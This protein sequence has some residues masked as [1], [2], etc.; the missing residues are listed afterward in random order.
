MRILTINPGSTSTKVAVFENT[1]RIAKATIRHNG[2]QMLKFDTLADQLP[3]RQKL[4]VEFL[5]EY[6]IELDTIDGFIGRGG[7]VRPLESGL[8]RVNETMVETLRNNTYGHHASNLGG[9]I[10]KA[11]AEKVGKEAYI[12]DP[13]VVDEMEPLAR[14]TGLNGIKRRSI[15]HALNQKAV[16]R[17]YSED[18]GIPYENLHLIV[19]H[20]GGG[21]S[22]GYHKNGRV[23]DVNN[24]LD[25]DGPMSPE[26]TG[27]LPVSSV[28]DLAKE[29]DTESLKRMVSAYGGMFSY[30]NTKDAEEVSDMI[31]EGHIEARRVVDAM[32]YQIAKEIGSLYALTKG[33]LDAIILTGGLAYNQDVI[34]PLIEMID[35]LGDISIHPGENELESLAFN[36]LKFLNGELEAKEY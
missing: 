4:I 3:L 2:S 19:A 36:M 10:A 34:Q 18:V 16:A 8:Y 29:S 31:A 15:F 25:G 5:H 7:L 23:V 1:K 12:A 26:R 35:H 24:A 9:L 33:Q 17:A 21:I 28:I 27:T 13:V 22:V 20:L 30:L 32:V 6:D 11:L 14:F